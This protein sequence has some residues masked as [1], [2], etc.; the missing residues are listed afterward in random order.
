MSS[1]NERTIVRCYVKGKQHAAAYTKCQ[2]QMWK[3][4]FIPSPSTVLFSLTFFRLESSFMNAFVLWHRVLERI[5]CLI[6]KY[7]QYTLKY[8]VD[9]KMRVPF[10]WCSWTFFWLWRCENHRR[11]TEM[12]MGD[13]FTTNI[14]NRSMMMRER[15]G[16]KFQWRM[17]L[18]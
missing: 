9:D 15:N 3:E 6:G 13:W 16:I 4:V 17:E 11:L 2:C 12:K 18:Q 5:D 7:I 8:Y 1:V 14:I 10:R